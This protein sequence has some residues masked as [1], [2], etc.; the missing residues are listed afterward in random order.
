[1]KA[2]SDATFSLR[3]YHL[4]LQLNA[5]GGADSADEAELRREHIVSWPVLYILTNSRQNTAYVGETTNFRR[6]MAQHQSNPDKDFNISLMIDSPIFNQSSTFD[7]ENR[8]IQLLFADQKYHVTNKNN[9]YCSFNYYQRAM[10]RQYFRDLWGRLH[11]IGYTERN[12]WEIE[13]SDLFKYSPYKQLTLDQYETINR[14]IDLVKSDYRTCTFVDGYPG[15]GKSILAISL[16]LKLRSIEDC[17]DM[18]VALVAPME[19]LKKTYR[20]IARSVEGLHAFDVIGPSDVVKKG[21]FDVLLV[22]EAHRMHGIGGAMFMSSYRA[23]CKKLG[24]S[25]SATQWDWMLASSPHVVFFFDPKQQVRATGMG[26]LDRVALLDR[27]ENEGYYVDTMSLTTQMRVVGGDDY[28]D[29]IYD[30]LHAGPTRQFA[31]QLFAE[32]F[33]PL[34][35]LVEQ[36]SGNSIPR[37]QFAIIDSFTDFCELQQEKE[38]ERGLSRMVA[39]YA[40]EWQSKKDSSTYD[41]EIDSIKKRWNSKTGGNWV[42]SP[43]AVEEV[44]SIHT[45]QGFDLNYGFVIVGS[46]VRYDAQSDSLDARRSG[47]MDCGAKKTSTDEVLRDVILNAYYVLMTRGIYGT[48]LYI[49]EDE[50]KRY[51][52]RFIPTI[53]RRGDGGYA[54]VRSAAP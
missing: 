49:C 41:I 47:F 16:L 18:K 38:Q 7:Y 30:V 19:Q 51:F 23:T 45:V 52:Q 6:R 28:L 27:L 48:F 3:E 21:P 26:L 34:P 12:L 8:L 4:P 44:G 53:R 46:D 43:H 13:N 25:D 42:N 9:G 22:D 50:V 24:L 29:F 39:G 54:V 36:D 2:C 5:L 35:S 15:T 1:M 20:E 37:Y 10:Y 11:D 40:W 32:D 33:S 14:I 17:K 31:A